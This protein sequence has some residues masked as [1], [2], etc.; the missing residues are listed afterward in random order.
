[1]AVM[2]M[3]ESFGKAYKTF[4]HKARIISHYH[5][6]VEL[7]IPVLQNLIRGEIL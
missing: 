2:A 3:E 7:L 6:S 5:H 1:M 4:E